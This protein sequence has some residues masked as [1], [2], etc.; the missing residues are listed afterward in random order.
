MRQSIRL[1]TVAGVAVG[2]NWSVAVI[3]ALFAAELAYDVLPPSSKTPTAADWV[4][5]VVGAL[6][7]GAS[8]LAHE[9]SHALVAQHNQVRVRSITLFVFGGVTQIEGE[10]QTAGADFRIAAVGP[11]T[12]VVCAAVLAAAEWA[13]VT[14]GDHGISVALLS[15]LWKINLLLAAFNLIPAAPLDGGRVLRA[16]LWRYWGQ[17]LVPVI[18]AG[19]SPGSVWV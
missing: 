14:G 7:L 12:S 2:V 15:W 5:G 4:A 10:A 13:L 18:V 17:R 19:H 11:A 9:V 8:L 1:G 3:L 16:G 6:V